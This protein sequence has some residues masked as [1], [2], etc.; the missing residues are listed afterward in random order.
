[1]F[2]LL[3]KRVDEKKAS[4][5]AKAVEIIFTEMCERLEVTNIEVVYI[6]G[7]ICADAMRVRGNS[8]EEI[9]GTLAMFLYMTTI[10]THVMKQVNRGN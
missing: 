3:M 6:L 10:T 4:K 9:D 7:L 1:M 2:N 8:D 5:V